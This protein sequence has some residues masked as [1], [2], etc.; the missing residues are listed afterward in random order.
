MAKRPTLKDVAAEAGVSIATVNRVIAA[1]PKVRKDTAI[2]VAEA[3]HA[4]GYHG[5]NL[6]THQVKQSLPLVRL[7]FVLHKERQRFYQDFAREIEAAAG[8]FPEARVKLE[9]EFCQSQS[10]KDVAEK[11]IDISKRVDVIAAT[12]VNHHKVSEVVADLKERG[13]A[14]FS[15]LSDFAQ[16]HR[17]AYYG[18]NNLKVGRGVA[19]ALSKFAQKPGNI[20]IFVGGNRW[21]GHELREAGFRAQF[22]EL[23]S[24]FN[25]LDTLVN[26]ETRQLTYEA[27]L[28]LLERTSNLV[29]IYLAGG[30]MEGT[31]QAFREEVEPNEIALIVNELTPE[32]FSALEEGY[33]SMIV[34]TP[35]QEMCRSLIASM[36]AHALGDQ[37]AS[38]KQVF[39][40]PALYLPE[41]H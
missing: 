21:H 38:A 3:A 2:R 17:E 39:F 30:G 16:G 23:P 12:S 8:S 9:L 34:S 20:A 10:P 5:Y 7:G 25:V 15:L 24:G 32:S 29:G 31:I 40:K 11:I 36:A 28:D 37:S 33:V 6:L 26:L 13:V 4:I 18:L 22:R 1:D 41:F 27:T 35:L 19:S 14:C